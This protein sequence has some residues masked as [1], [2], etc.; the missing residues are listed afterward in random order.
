MRADAQREARIA[1]EAAVARAVASLDSALE[2]ARRDIA[3]GRFA[4]SRRRVER[5]TQTDEDY[6][7]HGDKPAFA[8]MRSDLERR[9]AQTRLIAESLPILATAMPSALDQGLTLLIAKP[10]PAEVARLVGQANTPITLVAEKSVTDSQWDLQ[11]RHPTSP[12]SL[13][14]SSFDTAEKRLALA[15]ALRHLMQNSEDMGTKLLV[16][17]PSGPPAILG[18]FAWLTELEA[19]SHAA[20]FIEYAWQQLPAESE[21]RP[22]LREYYAWSLLGQASEAA[23]AGDRARAQ[24]LLARLEQDFA[25][26]RAN[27]PRQ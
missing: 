15:E 17:T 6:L 16:P 20:V 8:L 25:D 10:W 21:H 18:V 23:N 2:Q 4:A 12:R 24:A 26:T 22:L 19:H 1:L 13:A 27:K 11:L 5:W 7:A 9:E 14:A 3:L